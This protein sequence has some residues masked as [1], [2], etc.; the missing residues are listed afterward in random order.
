MQ[1][2]MWVSNPQTRIKSLIHY[3]LAN[4]ASNVMLYT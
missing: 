1:R 2:L 4:L 3:R